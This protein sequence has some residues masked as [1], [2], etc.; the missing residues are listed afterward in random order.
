MFFFITWSCAALTM[1][2]GEEVENKVHVVAV[3]PVG[4]PHLRARAGS[5]CNFHFHFLIQVK[6][7]TQ[8]NK[9]IFFLYYY[10]KKMSF[11]KKKIIM[12]LIKF[13]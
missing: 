9:E 8:D 6:E 12:M 3:Q 11:N 1:V 7:K 5:T 10:L 2:A 13:T 4:R